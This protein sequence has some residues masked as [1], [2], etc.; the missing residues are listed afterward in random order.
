[1]NLRFSNTDL[2]RFRLVAISEGIS[3]LLLLFIAMPLKYAAG[4]P[5]GVTYVGW[6]HGLLLDTMKGLKTGNLEEIAQ[7][8][9]PAPQS[10]GNLQDKASPGKLTAVTLHT[11]PKIYTEMCEINWAK[12]TGD[13]Y[14]LIRGLS[15]YPTAFTYLN[16]KKL[17]IFKAEK[18]ISREVSEPGKVLTD[19]RSFLK[20]STNDGYIILKDIQLEGKKRMMTEAF[21]RGWR[22]N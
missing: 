14:N 3:F 15:P 1:M 16:G 8:N 22:S 2:G 6:A 13:I 12:S 5:E 4:M 20:F 11:A 7:S 9:I 18:E 17:K 19:R 10:D 21:L